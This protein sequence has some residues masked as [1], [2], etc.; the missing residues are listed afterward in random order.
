MLA[1]LAYTGKRKDKFR[2]ELL[3]ALKMLQSG[4]PR[5][6]MKSSW[7]GAVGLT[8]AMPTEY[9]KYATDGDGDGK[10]D[11]WR[12]VADALAFTARQLEGKGWVRGAKRSVAKLRQAVADAGRDPRDVKIVIL[13]TVVVAPTDEEAQ[14]KYRK[15]VDNA[16]IDGILARFSGW[17]GI[18][19]SE[20]D[21]DEPL[22]SVGTKAAQSM[23]DLF[24][25]PTR[26]A[27][28]PCGRSR[29]SSRS[30]A[31]GAPVVGSPQT[32]AA[33]LPAG[34]TRPTSTASTSATPPSPGSWEDF[35]ELALPELRA[36]G[37]GFP[38]PHRGRGA[39]NPAR[40]ALR[41]EVHAGRPPCHGP[42][43]PAPERRGPLGAS[44]STYHGRYFND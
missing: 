26:T 43:C 12:S 42:A 30:A 17:T 31:P 28:G 19:M 20:Y 36:Q 24:S 8:Q 10:I 5:S 34:A 2:E 39:G 9:F 29:N 3:A 7:A 16:P 21:L 41:S 22:R 15:A 32:V 6:D 38:G 44:Q 25:R 37:T 13:L 18:D 35:I 11:L 4:I 23:V 40:E 1:T 27:S 14:A 33:E